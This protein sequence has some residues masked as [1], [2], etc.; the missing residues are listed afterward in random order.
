MIPKANVK[1][2]GLKIGRGIYVV[3]GYE[4][5]GYAPAHRRKTFKTYDRACR[6]SIEL[7]DYYQVPVK[8]YK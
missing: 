8:E 5:I 7:R 3:A 1:V 6:Y 4:R 2:I